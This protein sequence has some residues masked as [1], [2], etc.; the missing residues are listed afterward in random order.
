MTALFQ[1]VREWLRRLLGIKFVRDTLALQTGTLISVVVGV[2]SSIILV[3]GLGGY[4]YGL[5]SLMLT[6]YGLLTLTSPA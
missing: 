1:R 5:Y 6:M 4:Q 3:R 2:A